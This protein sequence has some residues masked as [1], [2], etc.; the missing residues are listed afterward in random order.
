MQGNSASMSGCAQKV[1]SCIEVGFTSWTTLN[2]VMTW[3]MRTMEPLSQDTPDDGRC[4]NWCHRTTGGQGCLGMLPSSLC[5]AC[6]QTKTFPMQKVGK[7]IPSK[8][9]DQCWQVISIDM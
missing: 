9:P 1:L 3:C 4:W 7:L 5:N 6:N 8:V 2:S